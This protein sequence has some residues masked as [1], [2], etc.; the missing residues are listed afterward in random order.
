MSQFVLSILA[1]IILW[2]IQSVWRKTSQKRTMAA[3]KAK[4]EEQAIITR[5]KKST[6]IE[7]RY[8]WKRQVIITLAGHC[9]I[10]AMIITVFLDDPPFLFERFPPL[11]RLKLVST[12]HYSL[13][14]WV[15]SFLLFIC[16]WILYGYAWWISTL[17][18]KSREAPN[19]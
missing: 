12:N 5:I 19:K 1:G 10:V 7:S 9:F 17:L 13:T 16:S 3:E 15:V 2:V 11:W 18:K 8:A 4:R 14:L 6:R